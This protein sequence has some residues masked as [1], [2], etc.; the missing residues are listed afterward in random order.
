MPVI[1]P[2]TPGQVGRR[3]GVGAAIGS[4]IQGYNH[5]RTAYQRGR[6][7][8]ESVRSAVRELPSGRNPSRR[9][10]GHN[11]RAVRRLDFGMANVKRQGVFVAGATNVVQRSFQKLKSGKKLSKKKQLS[12]LV[13][14]STADTI[15]RYQRIGAYEGFTASTDGPGSLE[16]CHKQL[17]LGTTTYFT[18]PVQLF[19]LTSMRYTYDDGVSNIG[20]PCQYQLVRYQSGAPLGPAGD[21]EWKSYNGQ[22]AENGSVAPAD[23]WVVER[24]AFSGPAGGGRVQM[25]GR[26]Y[27]DWADIRLVLYGARAQTTRFTVSLVQ[28][29]D[30]SFDP[31]IV[32]R[33]TAAVPD[34]RTA[35]QQDRMNSALDEMCQPLIF[36]PLHSAGATKNTVFKTM[37]QKNYVIGPDSFTNENQNQPNVLVHFFK[38]LNRLCNYQWQDT[39][40]Q[41]GDANFDTASFNSYIVGGNKS[42]L[43]PMARVYLMVTAQ[44]YT[45]MFPEG[46]QPSADN[47][48]CC[49]VIIRKKVLYDEK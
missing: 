24:N 28:I 48:P 14:A 12:K 17:V 40:K 32:R 20:S 18:M 34:S 45:R 37:F 26:C 16:L 33:Q 5:F 44:A 49:D 15:L 31:D 43:H 19:D 2:Y 3:I 13:K 7:A 25:G 41:V 46:P 38:R 9:L 21:Y 4:A 22:S 42:K 8:L 36:H 29:T 1:V 6:E 10:G 30:P 35:E 39:T 11:P 27:L 47:S 23:H